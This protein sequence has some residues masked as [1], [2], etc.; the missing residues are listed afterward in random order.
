MNGLVRTIASC[1]ILSCGQILVCHAQAVKSV[2]PPE[3]QGIDTHA[4]DTLFK[5]LA[6]DPHKDIKG[7][8]ILRN[9]QL[10]AESYFNGDD[11]DTLHD[12][13]SATKS[14]TATLVGLAIER[15][16]IHSVDDS[17][18]RYLPG[19]PQDGKQKIT[20]RDLLNMR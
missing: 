10:V 3:A 14:I 9:G 7:V 12:I 2:T 13:R 15:H 17:I 8:V 19:L 11:A 18:A 20:I 5:D 1:V 6:A 16:D 4:L